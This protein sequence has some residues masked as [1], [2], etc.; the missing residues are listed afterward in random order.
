MKKIVPKVGMFC[1]QDRTFSFSLIK[2]KVVSGIVGYVGRKGAL[3][4][5]LNEICLPWSSDFFDMREAIKLR[6]KALP[7]SRLLRGIQVFREELDCVLKEALQQGKKFEA[8][9]WCSVFCEDAVLKGEA[10]LPK[11]DWLKLVFQHKEQINASLEKLG[12]SKLS[13]W[14]W[15]ATEANL[16]CAWCLNADNGDS[17]YCLKTEEKFVRPMFWVGKNW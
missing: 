12:L 17:D 7:Y 11:Y 16:R 10:F 14:Y 6:Y 5:S 15:S 3:V 1:Y 13:G 9:R 2:G 8:I 4:V